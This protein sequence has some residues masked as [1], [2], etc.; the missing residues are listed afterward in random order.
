MSGRHRGAAR[1]LSTP[2]LPRGGGLVLFVAPPCPDA[3]RAIG[4]SAGVRGGTMH[5]ANDG[6]ASAGSALIGGCRLRLPVGCESLARRVGASTCTR[7]RSTALLRPSC[8][9]LGA[10]RHRPHI[11]H[12]ARVTLISLEL[13]CAQAHM[14][15]RSGD[16][17]SNIELL[18]AANCVCERYTL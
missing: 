9:H 1:P 15:A 17:N 10:G 13:T 5:A 7:P 12:I 18:Y 2:S 11:M 4:R 14:R 8:V 3:R 6:V 16:S